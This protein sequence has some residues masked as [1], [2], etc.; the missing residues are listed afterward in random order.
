MPEIMYVIADS[1]RGSMLARG[2]L[3]IVKT[4]PNSAA[5]E[6]TDMFPIMAS[7]RSSVVVIEPVPALVR[8]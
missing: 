4:D 3:A 8:I 7:L 1:T 5:A 6:R 2:I